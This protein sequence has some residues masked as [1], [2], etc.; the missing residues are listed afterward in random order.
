M[1]EEEEERVVAELE[2]VNQSMCIRRYALVA[3]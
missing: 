2:V 1:E 3:N